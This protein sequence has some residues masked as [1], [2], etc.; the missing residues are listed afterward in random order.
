[1]AISNLLVLSQSA[2][3]TVS[4]VVSVC[5]WIP[6]SLH[7][8]AFCGN[9]SLYSRGQYVEEDGRFDA[10]WASPAYCVFTLLVGFFL[11]LMA[12]TQMSRK[13]VLLYRGTDSTFLSAFIDTVLS[14]IATILVL[15]DAVIVTKGFS[16]W[17]RSVAIRFDSCETAASVMV[18]GKDT[19][20]DPKGFFLELGS[21]QFGIWSLMVCWVLSLVLASRKLF[22]YHE[23][24][25]MIVSMARE[26]Q[27]HLGSDYTRLVT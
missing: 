10:D 5:V 24:E 1:M 21:V 25:N 22:V 16:I 13:F 6:I 14:L 15:T 19:N 8:Y 7:M 17:C 23:R 4:A 26:R 11:F 12:F 2:V 18:I 9:C 20:I 3:Y 27:R